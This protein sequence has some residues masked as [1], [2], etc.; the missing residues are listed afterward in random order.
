MKRLGLWSSLPSI[1][2]A[3]DAA[4]GMSIFS[5]IVFLSW[6]PFNVNKC[7]PTLANVWLVERMVVSS[8]LD[9]TGERTPCG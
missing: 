1:A 9:Q 3:Y 8:T 7:W 4:M 6:F 5:P 2:R